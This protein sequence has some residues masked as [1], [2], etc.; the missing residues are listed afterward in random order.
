MNCVYVLRLEEGKYYIGR[1]ELL[2]RP[3][4]HFTGQ[5]ACWTKRF[6][7]LE[8]VE[9]IDDCDKIVERLKT[10]EYMIKFGWQNVRGGGWSAT[11][12]K[13]PK[14]LSLLTP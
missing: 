12:I 1:S 11:I 6:K 4:A 9:K 14:A 13:L 3:L 2:H 10:L 5:G 8:V 7:P